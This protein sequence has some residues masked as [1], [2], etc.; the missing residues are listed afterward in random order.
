MHTHFARPQDS[1]SALATLR[2]HL[3]VELTETDEHGRYVLEFEA[4]CECIDALDDLEESLGDDA[5]GGE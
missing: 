4:M 2:E 1:A 5:E 3:D